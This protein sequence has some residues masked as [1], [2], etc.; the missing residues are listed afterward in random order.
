MLHNLV[1]MITEA[2]E[3]RNKLVL[4]MW[5]PSVL[6]GDHSITTGFIPDAVDI[7]EDRLVIYSGGDIYS[8]NATDII[9][10]EIDDL[11]QCTGATT[12]VTIEAT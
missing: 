9:Y 1:A 7:G 2:I 5:A 8:L 3:G 6:S 12:V 4:S 11:Y 10:D